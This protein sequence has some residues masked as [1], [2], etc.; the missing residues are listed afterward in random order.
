MLRAWR[1]ARDTRLAA[2]RLYAAVTAQA[3]NPAFFTCLGL[4]DSMDSRFDLLCLHAW[5]VLEK[6]GPQRPL[7]QAFVDAVFV[8]FDEAL[9]QS[10]TGDVGMNRRLKTMAGAFY[11]RLGAY[12]SAATLDELTAAVRRNVFRD[13]EP[14]SGEAR[15]L[16]AYASDT[17]SRLKEQDLS[18]GNVVFDAFPTI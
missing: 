3:R 16:A 14:R 8:G 17:L 18:D 12:R 2:A 7:A 4:P 1:R 13:A 6:L 10:G 5:L 9:R 15:A 11:G